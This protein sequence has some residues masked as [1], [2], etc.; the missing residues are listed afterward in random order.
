MPVVASAVG[1]I[2][3]IID[4]G[5]N[6]ILVEKENS[7]D[8]FSTLVLLYDNADL[9]TRLGNNLKHTIETEFSIAKMAKET[10][11]VYLK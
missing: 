4:S 10:F 2:P 5:A 3:E 6:G 1:G 8:L 7:D 11:K 9:R